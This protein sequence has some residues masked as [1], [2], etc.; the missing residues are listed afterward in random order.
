MRGPRLGVLR[1]G[2]LGVRA[3]TSPDNGCPDSAFTDVTCTDNTCSGS[4][5]AY[6]GAWLCLQAHLVWAGDYVWCDL[7]MQHR[8]LQPRRRQRRRLVHGGGPRVRGRPSVGVLQAC[9][10]GARS[11]HTCTD[12][13]GIDTCAGDARTDSNTACMENGQGLHLQ[14][15][16]GVERL[17]ILQ[18]L[19]LQPGGQR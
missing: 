10:L 5:C 18:L 1:A 4:I 12:N 16:L 9:C 13:V 15:D 17:W 3:H 7:V 19:L 14:A 2:R 6:N 11:D 8:L